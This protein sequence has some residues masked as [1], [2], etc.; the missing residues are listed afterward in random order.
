M[1]NF[2]VLIISLLSTAT[3]ISC[4]TNPQWQLKGSIDGIADSLP[5][6]IVLEGQN[7]VGGW[8]TIDTLEVSSNGAFEVSGE[9]PAYPEIYRL[10][11]G[12]KSVYFPIDS[13][14]H[15]AFTGSAANFDRGYKLTGSQQA[16]RMASVDSLIYSYVSANG[17]TSL[18]TAMTLKRRLADVIMI[19]PSSIVSYYIVNKTVE[20]HP[21]LNI[22]NKTDLRIIGAVANG[23]T[24]R[25]SNDP[26]CRLISDMYL[27]NMKRHSTAPRDT[28]VA[29]EIG[30]I[31][32]VLPD[33]TG[34][35][36][37]LSDIS[38]KNKVVVLNFTSYSQDFSAPL[39][40]ELRK[41]YDRYHASGLEI[42]QVGVENASAT[43]NFE[44]RQSAR[45]LPWVTVYN[46]TRADYLSTYNVPNVP[47]IFVISGNSIVSRPS[48]AE[49][50]TRT[51]NQLLAQ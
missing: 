49:E 12:G 25:R 15:L 17:V 46:G 51:V 47:S 20:G 42:F 18:D 27:Q 33:A 5:A 32:I 22:D 23:F 6:A 9:A 1:R 2:K 45:N 14:E 43:D 29:E 41:L 13:M 38:D 3:I 39:N 26:R 11:Y 10:T 31:D 8:Y 19:D 44:W 21:L 24:E 7:K 16:E 37:K 4:N 36:V 34:T 30:M 50:L 40:I 28:I 35:E 48:G